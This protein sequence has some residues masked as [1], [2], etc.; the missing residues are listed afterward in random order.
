MYSYGA[1]MPAG[2][3]VKSSEI[4]FTKSK[5]FDLFRISHVNLMVVAYWVPLSQRCLTLSLLT[6]G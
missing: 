1:P 3:L 5:S 6:N 2:V 4:S